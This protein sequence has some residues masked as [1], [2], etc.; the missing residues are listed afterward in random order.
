MHHCTANIPIILSF[1]RM[2]GYH[3]DIPSALKFVSIQPK[4]L[5]YQSGQSV[6]H[7]TICPLFYSQRLLFCYSSIHSLIH[8]LLNI[9]WHTIFHTCI[10]FENPCSFLMILTISKSPILNLLITSLYRFVALKLGIHPHF[11]NVR[12]PYEVKSLSQ[13]S[14]IIPKTIHRKQKATNIAT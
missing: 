4:T 14:P 8:T 12:L 5:S 2:S 3:Y 1:C 7:H 6:S 10:F 11:S 13:T 9:C